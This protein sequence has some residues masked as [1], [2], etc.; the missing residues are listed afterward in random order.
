MSIDPELR[1]VTFAADAD[2]A[3]ELARAEVYGVL[4]ALFYAPPDAAMLAQFQVAVPFLRADNLLALPLLTLGVPVL[5]HRL[6]LQ[7][8]RHA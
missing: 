2:D 7:G 4:A 8:G 5:N 1:P 3:E 6:Q